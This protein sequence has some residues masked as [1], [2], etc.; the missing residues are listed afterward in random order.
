MNL[1]IYIGLIIIASISCTVSIFVFDEFGFVGLFVT[2]I[3]GCFLLLHVCDMSAKW[4][5]RILDFGK[6]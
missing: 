3:K 2:Q 1:Y 5:K 6:R 4:Y